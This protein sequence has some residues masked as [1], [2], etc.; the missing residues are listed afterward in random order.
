L[1]YK[2]S[3]FVRIRNKNLVC[4]RAKVTAADRERPRPSTTTLSNK[5]LPVL[6]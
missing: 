3:C 4:R 2:P 6:R 1:D 5:K